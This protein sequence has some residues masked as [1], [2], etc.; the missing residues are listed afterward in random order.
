MN[1][2]IQKLF[3]AALSATLNGSNP[4]GDIDKMYIPNA[5]VV[6]FAELIVHEC[7]MQCNHADD[8]DILLN[9]FGIE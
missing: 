2:K 6:K 7:V 9:H 3:T 5:F 4:D 8:M 1:T